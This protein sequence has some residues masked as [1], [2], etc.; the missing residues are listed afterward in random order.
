M[1]QLPETHLSLALSCA[2]NAS[3]ILL[4]ANRFPSDVSG[5]DGEG[6]KLVTA[7]S[8]FKEGERER[9]RKIKI[10]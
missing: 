1:R 7:A 10:A 9:D 5:G 2:L 4:M 6:G 3:L 8:S